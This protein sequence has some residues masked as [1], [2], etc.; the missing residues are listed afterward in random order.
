MAFC[1]AATSGAASELA[2]FRSVERERCVGAVTRDFEDVAHRAVIQ[3][4]SFEYPETMGFNSQVE[5]SQKL[6]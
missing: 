2:F 3:G 5:A 4:V 1:R 6:R